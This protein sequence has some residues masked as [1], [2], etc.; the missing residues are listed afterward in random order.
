MCVEN[1]A[2]KR[3]KNK[4]LFTKKYVYMNQKFFSERFTPKA[5]MYA[6]AA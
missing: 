1:S 6:V 2:K 3:A 4:I 5:L